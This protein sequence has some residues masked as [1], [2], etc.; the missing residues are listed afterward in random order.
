MTS[1]SQSS[2]SPTTAM[3]ATDL[4][5]LPLAIACLLESRFSGR[6]CGD[7]M[8]SECGVH[9]MIGGAW[10]AG[11]MMKRPCVSVLALLLLVPRAAEV[12]GG[13]ER[14]TTSLRFEV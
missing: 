5:F 12:Q 8:G 4:S 13:T 14:S 10:A 11:E 3:L 6:S 1:L 2:T 9:V 7:T